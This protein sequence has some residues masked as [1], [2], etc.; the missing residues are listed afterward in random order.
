M[1][2]RT[3]A[4]TS[5][6]Q[7]P[8]DVIDAEADLILAVLDRLETQEETVRDQ[9]EPVSAL[10]INE[11]EMERAIHTQ[12]MGTQG[13]HRRSAFR[14]NITNASVTRPPINEL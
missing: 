4:L 14:V 2:K 8:A 7:H 13:R 12:K 9:L 5:L 3:Y 11:T 6:G 10:P 1:R